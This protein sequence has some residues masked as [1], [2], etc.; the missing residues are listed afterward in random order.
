MRRASREARSPVGRLLLLLGIP[1]VVMAAAWWL[2]RPAE[3]VS[4]QQLVAEASA[5]LDAGDIERAYTIVTALRE[6]SD[7]SEVLYL[8]AV[9]EGLRG[10]DERALDVLSGISG[11]EEDPRLLTMAAQHA[12][13]IPRL[14]AARRYLNLAIKRMPENEEAIRLLANL[15]G[16]LMNVLR[17]RQLIVALDGLG[18][19]TAQDV[20][21]FCSGRRVTYDLKENV[22]RLI[23]A[24]Q[25]DPDEG[26]LVYA[27]AGNYMAMAQLEE[28]AHVIA[29]AR[30]RSVSQDVWMVEQAAAELAILRWDFEAAAA[31]LQQVGTQGQS[32]DAYWLAVGRVLRERD[33]TQAAIAAYRNAVQLDPFDPEPL[34]VLSALLQQTDPDE[35]ARLLEQKRVLQQLGA[36]VESILRLPSIEEAAERFPEAIDELISA[37]AWREARICLTWLKSEGYEL[38]SARRADQRLRALVSLP[39]SQLKPP[40]TSRLTDVDLSLLQTP[41]E[42]G[43]PSGAEPT[44]FDIDFVDLT[45]ALGLDFEYTFPAVDRPSILESLGGGVA[46][47]DFDGDGHTDLF[48]P[49]AGDFPWSTERADQDA[50]YRRVAGV[51]RNVSLAAGIG[52]SDYGHGTAVA[53]V[54]ADGFP[55]LFVTNDGHNQLYLN[56]GDGTFREASDDVGITSRDWSVSAAFGD[57]DGDGDPDLYVANYLIRERCRDDERADEECG[58]MHVP[59]VQDRLYENAGDG[60]FRDITESSGI[61]NSHGKGLGVVV[62]DF[63]GDGRLDVFVGNDTTHNRLLYNASAGQILFEDESVTSGV[64]VAS[65]GTA[66]ATMGIA[67]DDLDGNGFADIFVTNFESQTNSYYSNIDGR[68]F[69]DDTAAKDLARSSYATMGWGTQLLDLDDDGRKDLIMLN[70]QLHDRPMRPQV[71]RNT[72]DMFHSHTASAG[73]FAETRLGRGLAVADMNEDGRPDLLATHRRGRPRILINQ[74][75]QSP[76]CA[77]RLIATTGLRH[78]AGAKV[79]V[80]AGD[81]SATHTLHAGGGYLVAN[82]QRV[83]LVLPENR[84]VKSITIEWPSG[85]KQSARDVV[86]SARMTVRQSGGTPQFRDDVQ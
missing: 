44:S 32:F 76:R 75:G 33:Q 25:N 6:S 80:K 63:D 45:D 29:T 78:A 71:Y 14:V 60:T 11:F 10:H 24:W 61:V 74:S 13:K 62:R 48:F 86:L 51:F 27:L 57:F 50:L 68:T 30:D 77:L 31:A 67:S 16:N 58:P 40:R 59:A 23:A 12:L 81:H 28:A 35:A 47:L 42:V 4:Q 85:E 66:E 70:G 52:A 53:D 41:P 21:L 34:F 65:D 38:E 8:L 73:Y 36:R 1:V 2:L 7:D 15:E 20:F 19:C 83:W 46:A 84:R 49:Q 82:E 26:S 69:V 56:N 72:G 18:R 39:P 3:P 79:T 64:A 5:A 17:L 55:D 22:G 37:G 9:I 54:D 43:E